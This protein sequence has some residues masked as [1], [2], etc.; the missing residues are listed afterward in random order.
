MDDA[1]D[2]V[3]VDKWLWAARFF[4]TRTLASNAV[5]AGQVRVNDE[6]VKPARPVRPGDRVTIRKAG[7]E[8]NAEVIA[9]ADRR[10]SATQAALLYHEPDESRRAREE[11][12]ARLRAVRDGHEAPSGR[13]T[14]RDRRRLED[15]LNEP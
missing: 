15:F 7:L 11:A 2:K 8:W 14:K 9:L 6:R 5:E 10:G 13:P 3:R 12:F 4:K 1:V